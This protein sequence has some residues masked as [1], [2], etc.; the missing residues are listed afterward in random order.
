MPKIKPQ[1]SKNTKCVWARQFPTFPV[2]DLL[3]G[4]LSLDGPS[5]DKFLKEALSDSEGVRLPE[6]DIWVI[7]YTTY[8][9]MASI[10]FL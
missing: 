10:C 1:T 5:T 4:S 6:P 3:V 7:Q 9:Y 2:L 8:Y